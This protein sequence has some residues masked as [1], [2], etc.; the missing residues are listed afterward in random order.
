MQHKRA[1]HGMVHCITC[2]RADLRTCMSLHMSVHA[3]YHP[4][5]GKH[6]LGRLSSLSPG[7][8]LRRPNSYV[9]DLQKAA[10]PSQLAGVCY[11][12]GIVLVACTGHAACHSII[13]RSLGRKELLIQCT[14]GVCSETHSRMYRKVQDATSRLKTHWMAHSLWTLLSRDLMGQA[15]AAQAVHPDAAASYCI[16][17]LCSH[18]AQHSS[19]HGHEESMC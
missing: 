19:A 16:S 1:F 17:K 7:L 5:K 10:L 4:S 6:L 18:H 9:Q 14:T 3:C 11:A 12:Q 8:S 2:R 15:C 13:C